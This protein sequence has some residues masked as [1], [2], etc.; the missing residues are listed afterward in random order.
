MDAEKREKLLDLY[1]KTDEF[2]AKLD[3][4]FVET[5]HKGLGDFKT[6]LKDNIKT[7]KPRDQ[8]IVL[9]AGT[10]LIH[11]KNIKDSFNSSTGVYMD[12]FL[13]IAVGRTCAM[14]V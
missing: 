8:Y 12:C 2:V 9:V 11:S 3:A 5:L 1:V 14:F 4:D 13:E 6:T 7:V 10:F